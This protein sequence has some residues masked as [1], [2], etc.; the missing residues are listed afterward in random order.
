MNPEQASS[1]A[2][3]LQGP[4]GGWVACVVLAFILG[5]VIVL[6]V[7]RYESYRTAS[8]KELKEFI[9]TNS[10]LAIQNKIQNDQIVALLSAV[11]SRLD[12]D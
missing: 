3:V 8:E 6:V 4:T 5:S 12:K 11:K 1:W 2:A 7:R 10:E 9:K